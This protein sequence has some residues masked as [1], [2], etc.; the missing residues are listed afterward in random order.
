MRNC[1]SASPDDDEEDVLA[2]MII[3]LKEQF[4]K[5]EGG[6]GL[7]DRIGFDHLMQTTVMQTLGAEMS[8]EEVQLHMD[9]CWED[10]DVLDEGHITF[11]RIITVLPHS[12]P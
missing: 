1:A 9:S 2:L 5:H 10:M 12:E 7:I 6:T 3:Q 8:A 4:M 11:D